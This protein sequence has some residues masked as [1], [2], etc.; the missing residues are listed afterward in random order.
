MKKIYSAVK[1][2]FDVCNNIKVW[3]L[4]HIGSFGGSPNGRSTILGRFPK[5]FPGFILFLEV[6]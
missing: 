2:L 5:E 4:I 1:T 6:L 3:Y